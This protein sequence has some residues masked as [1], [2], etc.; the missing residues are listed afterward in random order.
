MTLTDAE[1][2]LV[3]SLWEKIA[4]KAETL[5]AEAMDRLLK[6]YPDTAAYFSKF[7]LTTNSPDMLAHGGKIMNALGD[8]IKNYDTMKDSMA[9]LTDQHVN[10]IAV[11]P[12]YYKLMSH[13]IQIV[14]AVHFPTEF[15]TLMNCA[16]NDFLGAVSG[17]LSG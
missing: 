2:A 16:W 6:L 17:I 1:K 5:G 4:P 12:N 13:C 8:A 14:L 9:S 3:L 10:K 7:D 15:T 11:D